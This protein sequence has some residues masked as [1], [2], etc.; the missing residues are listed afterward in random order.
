MIYADNAATTPLDQDSFEAMKPFLLEQY[1]NASQ[2][3]SFAREPRT[4]LK[5]ARETIADCIG[6]KPEEN[7]EK[8]ETQEKQ[9]S[10]HR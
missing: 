4:A 7:L 9:N 5:W 6:A 3:Y 8:Q 10:I 1:G 2:P